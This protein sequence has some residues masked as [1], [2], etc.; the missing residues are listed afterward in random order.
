MTTTNEIDLQGSDD[1]IARW[2]WR[3]LVPKSGQALTVQGE[4]LRA[5]EKLRW[6]AQENGNINWDH[7][8]EML[9]GFLYEHLVQKSALPKQAKESIDTDLSRLRD[10]LPVDELEDDDQAGGLPYIEDDL[11]DRLTS[12]VVNFCRLN[13]KLIPRDVDPNQ[14]R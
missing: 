11:Y 6:E 9:V 8:F 12:Q 7:C 4:L 2:V 14:Y 5:I 13:P 10:F 1:D 3:N